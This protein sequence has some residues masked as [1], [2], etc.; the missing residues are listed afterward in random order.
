MNTLGIDIGATRIKMAVVSKDRI[1]E[2][3]SVFLGPDDHSE[4][5]M[6]GL[7]HKK[8]AKLNSRYRIGSVGIGVAGVIDMHTGLIRQS[9]NFPTWQDF[10]LG[11]RLTE[12]TGLPVAMDN[13]ANMVAIGEYEFGAGK[14]AR[15]MALLTLGS[16]VGGGLIL[17]G[18]LFHGN[19]GMAGE[20]GHI[21][22]EPEGFAC[23]CGN[24]GCLEQ[25]ASAKGLRNKVR[26]DIFF[27]AE[28][29]LA[30]KDPKLPE[31]LYKMAKNGDKK[32]LG[33]FQEFGYYLAIAIGGM[34]NLLNIKLI[35]FSGG[36]AGSMDIWKA[37]L[38]QELRR[39]TFTAILKDVR[40]EQGT[41]G[42]MAGAIGA[43]IL[44]SHSGKNIGPPE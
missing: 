8:I 28:T 22:V 29:G 32:A 4:D 17:D 41:L 42:D 39:R 33:Y 18:R 12:A 13:D 37:V 5:G 44:G 9:P 10:A 7:L 30:L 16:G 21:T 31:R 6:I 20:I 14:G 43:A 34:L 3:A 15:N 27:G 11:Q 1:V 19:T 25:Y 23:N 36:V 40:I 35:V 24:N 26:R 2:S 38:M